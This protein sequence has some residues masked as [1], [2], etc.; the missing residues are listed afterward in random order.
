MC[1]GA[2]GE[3]EIEGGMGERR[4]DERMRG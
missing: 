4:E 2:G 1:V 3:R